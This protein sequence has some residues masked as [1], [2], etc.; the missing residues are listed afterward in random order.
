MVIDSPCLSTQS[1][2][3]DFE[4]CF[5]SLF[6]KRLWPT[7][8]NTPIC[9]IPPPNGG[10]SLTIA[11]MKPYRILVDSQVLILFTMVKAIGNMLSQFRCEPLS[12]LRQ[13]AITAILRTRF[14]APN[15][16]TNKGYCLKNHLIRFIVP[17]L[18]N[19]LFISASRLRITILSLNVR[20]DKDCGY[21]G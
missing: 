1:R 12:Q 20:S 6:L 17:E 10:F 4:C 14:I 19:D 9:P 21:Q 2:F 15:W 3:R 5:Q 13:R 16:A 7:I 11:S 18:L 8:I